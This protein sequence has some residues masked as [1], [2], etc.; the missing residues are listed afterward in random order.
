[1]YD[2]LISVEEK[3]EKLCHEIYHAGNV[4]YSEVALTKLEEIKNLDL[5]HL[6]VCISKTQYSISD[7]AKKLGYPMGHEMHVRDIELY[8][9]A[10][11]VTVLMGTTIKMPGLPKVPNYE[12]IYINATCRVQKSKK[13]KKSYMY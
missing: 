11:F 5:E 8:N 12:K 7:D 4:T 3:I 6:P 10:G 9:G 13:S 2:D 1:M